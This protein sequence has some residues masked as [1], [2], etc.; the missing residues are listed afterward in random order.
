M[1]TEYKQPSK[2]DINGKSQAKQM[3][4]QLFK[5]KAIQK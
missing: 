4:D 2:P 3:I 5:K 1:K